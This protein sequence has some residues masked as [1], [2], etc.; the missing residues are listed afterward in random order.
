MNNS[1]NLLTFNETATSK[2]MHSTQLKQVKLPCNSYGV[3]P[4]ELEFGKVCEFLAW[5]KPLLQPMVG[6]ILTYTEETDILILITHES[7]IVT[8]RFSLVMDIN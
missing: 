7:E 5:P 8:S 6:R 3:Y 1:L 2:H 4:Y